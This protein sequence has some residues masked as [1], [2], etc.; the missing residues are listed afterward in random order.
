MQHNVM[1]TFLFAAAVCIIC[2]LL[3]STSAV[4]LSDRQETN[5]ALDKMKN[6][7]TVSGLAEPGEKLSPERAQEIF[8]ESVRPIVIDLETGKP[9]DAVDPLTYDQQAAKTD[10]EMSSPAPPNPAAVKRLPKYAVIYEIL[11]EANEPSQI[12]LPV[13]GYGLWSTLYGFLAVDAEDLNTITGLSFYQHGETAGLG[14]EVDNPNWKALWPGRK[15]FDERG[16]VTIEV[17]KGSAG[18]PEEDPY[19]VDGLS[20]ATLTAD[21]VENMLHF[22]MTEGYGKFLDEYSSREST[23]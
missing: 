6:V 17:I 13:E 1:Y 4:S 9:T 12:V 22:W 5:A 19:R 11:D 23:S 2:G 21:G 14:G 10:P 7:L 15:V 20:G 16:D 3:V 8:S 18:P